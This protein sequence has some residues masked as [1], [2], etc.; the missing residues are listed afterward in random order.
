[1]V[2]MADATNNGVAHS[3]ITAMRDL[4]CRRSWRGIGG[5]LALG[6][7]KPI[8]GRSAALAQSVTVSSKAEGAQRT[9]CFDRHGDMHDAM[10]RRYRCIEL[11]EGCHSHAGLNHK[12]AKSRPLPNKQNSSKSR[13]KDRVRI[14]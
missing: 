14:T 2:M 4:R 7:V 10:P 3:T 1:M 12:Q 8:A 13:R 11:W 9:R 6:Q 5:G